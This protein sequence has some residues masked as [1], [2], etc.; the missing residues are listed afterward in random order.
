MQLPVEVWGFKE[1]LSGKT[2]NWA[3]WLCVCVCVCVIWSSQLALRNQGHYRSPNT[4]CI[5]V[6]PC[7]S[8]GNNG[9]HTYYFQSWQ[10]TS[11]NQHTYK[12]QIC[13]H[14]NT[15]S[16]QMWTYWFDHAFTSAWHWL[17]CFALLHASLASAERISYSHECVSLCV[18]LSK[19][20]TE[21]E[22]ERERERERE[23]ES[24]LCS[25]V[26]VHPSCI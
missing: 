16:T 3:L 20:N 8:E 19:R 18:C 15:E 10:I 17:W 26:H 25:F 2:K 24:C 13:I 5:Q 22:S 9:G 21:R 14:H 12:M 4:L 6:Q 7:T 23:R 1:G 11:K